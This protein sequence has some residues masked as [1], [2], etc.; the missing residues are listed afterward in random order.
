MITMYNEG[1]DIPQQFYLDK[2]E[3]VAA[4]LELEGQITIKLGGV[5][6]SQTLNNQYRQ[7]DKPTDV[8]SFPFNEKLPDGYYIGDIH[9][10]YAIALEQ[11]KENSI[12]EQQEIFT[13]MVHGLLH[14]AGHDHE[15]E[16]DNGEMMALQDT[17]L[18]DHYRE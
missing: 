11:A 3:A 9:I 12:S 6:E 5:E 15:S 14:L 16:D 7:I 8:L 1:I 10:C 2:L 18:K 13:L 4:H 17:L